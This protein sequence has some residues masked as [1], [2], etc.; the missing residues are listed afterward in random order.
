MRWW[1]NRHWSALILLIDMKNV[2]PKKGNLTIFNQLH[3]T[4]PNHNTEFPLWMYPDRLS[5]TT[6]KYECTRCLQTI[7][8]QECTKLFTECYLS[9]SSIKDWLNKWWDLHTMEYYAAMKHDREECY[10]RIRNDFQE[11]LLFRK[12]KYKKKKCLVC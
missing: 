10:V 5:P 6:W 8:K 4:K 2:T 7:W 3:I 9:L 1:K 11:I 12:A